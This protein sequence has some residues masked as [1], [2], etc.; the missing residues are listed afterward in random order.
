MGISLA[1]SFYDIEID[2]N[3][4]GLEITDTR[5]KEYMWL[6]SN[7][8]INNGDDN[9][10]LVDGVCQWTTDSLE[11]CYKSQAKHARGGFA[12]VVE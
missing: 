3:K 7:A 9:Y 8:L 12:F 2:D 1:T 6:E 4:Q 5:C 10:Y 11:I